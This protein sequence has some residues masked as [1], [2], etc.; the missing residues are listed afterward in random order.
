VRLGQPRGAVPKEDRLDEVIAVATRLFRENGFRATRL[1]DI[2]EALGVTRAA[3]YY[4]FDSK[5]DVLEE[6]C[7]RAMASTEAALRRIQD[8]DDPGARLHG[9]AHQYA[10]NMAGDA[11]RVFAR[12]NQEL[13]PTFRRGLMARARAVNDGAE[14]ILRYGIE[15][16]AFDPD[17]DVAVTVRGFLGMLN[18]L[19]EWHR[20]KRDGPLADTADL[21][22]G[23]FITGLA[24][25]PS[26]GKSGRN[27]GSRAALTATGSDGRAA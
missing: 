9:F 22:V 23:V 13:R 19:A 21:L 26:K 10:Q 6:V 5:Q 18:S 15:H 1:D 17:L 7:S 27:S 8:L 2:A 20:A 24:V 4:Y 16:G 14:E 25:R 11:A 3:L 12:D